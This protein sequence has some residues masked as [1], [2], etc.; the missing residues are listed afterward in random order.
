MKLDNNEMYL[1]TR[2]YEEALTN[3]AVL[4]RADTP[5]PSGPQAVAIDDIVRVKIGR[6]GAAESLPGFA[7]VQEQ[8]PLTNA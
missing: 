3:I 2:R 5:Q 7:I 4:R 8:K 6:N 1:V